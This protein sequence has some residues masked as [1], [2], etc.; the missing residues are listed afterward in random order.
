LEIGS[1]KVE[2]NRY[3]KNKSR[4][5]SITIDSSSLRDG[6]TVDSEKVID[7]RLLSINSSNPVTNGTP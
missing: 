4:D 3:L 5:G 7:Y 1:E 6:N 2:T